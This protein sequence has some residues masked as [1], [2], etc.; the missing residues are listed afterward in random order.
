[1]LFSIVSTSIYISTS[2]VQDSLFSTSSPTFIV[3]IHFDDSH[4]DRY[5]VVSHCDFDLHFLDH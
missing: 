2:S 5:E 3:C 4:F 1:M